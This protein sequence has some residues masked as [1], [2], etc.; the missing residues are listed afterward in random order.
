MAKPQV[1]IQMYSVRDMCAED[2]LGAIRQIAG[3]GYR[4]IELA[5]YYGVSASELKATLADVGVNAPSAHIGLDLK[6]P[7]ADQVK[8]QLEYA[9]ELG[10]K[11][12]IVPYYPLGDNP[13]EDDVAKMASILEEAAAIVTEGGL[14]FGYHNHAF[15]FKKVNG[16]PAIDLLLARVSPK[17]LFAEF[18]LGWVKVGGEDPAAYVKKYAGRVPVVHA[19]DF[20]ADGSD[21][22]I[23]KG[24]VD[25]DSA[26][27]A[28]EEVGVEY[29]IIEQE[30]YEVSSLQSA[31]NNLEWFKNRGW[32]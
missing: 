26:L 14:E 12:Y 23:G 13:T 31:K 2:F 21:A 28:V 25:W 30:Q 4:N 8:K 27:A 9:L 19:K 17:L 11:R 3:I 29:V 7:I 15:E 5:G 16:T 24:S 6:Q 18:D 10:L 20:K 1:G 22:E 32:N